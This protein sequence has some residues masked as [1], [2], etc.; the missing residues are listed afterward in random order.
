MI[1]Y[2]LTLILFAGTLQAQEFDSNDAKATLPELAVQGSSMGEIDLSRASILSGDT[3]ESRKIAS[4][5]DLSGLAPTLYVN[6]N[7]LQSY[8]DVITLRGIGNT[9]LFGSPGVQMYVDGVPQGNVFSYGAELYN[10]EGVEIFKGPQVAQFGKLAP[11]GAI[12]LISRKPGNAKTQSVSA[13]VA[14]FKY[15]ADTSTA[16]LNAA[17]PFTLSIMSKR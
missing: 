2:T 9:Q 14:S 12:N 16:A 17:C 6:S 13:S 8:G 3:I 4:I 10:L 15:V 7:G 11:G 1:K 5:S